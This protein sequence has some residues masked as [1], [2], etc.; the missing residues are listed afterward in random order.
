MY[1]TP[2]ARQFSRTKLK[3]ESVLI[4]VVVLFPSSERP[5][6]MKKFQLSEMNFQKSENISA[7]PL[8]Q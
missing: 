7:R 4:H 2:F 6:S 3:L 1:Q 5:M 8:L